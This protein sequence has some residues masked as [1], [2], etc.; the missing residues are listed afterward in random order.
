M[1]RELQ[2]AALPAVIGLMGVA[3]YTLLQITAPQPAP[4]LEAPRPISV[5]VEPAIR[6]LTRPT[7]V[8]FGEVRPAVRTE[9]VAQVGGKVVA[10]S[11]AFIEGGK[12][13]PDD[14]LLSIEDTDYRAAMEEVVARV[15][16]AKLEL[17]QALADADVARK[18]LAAQ[19]NPSPLALR[20][21]QVARAESALR[22]AQ[23][24]LSLAKT[25][26]ERTQ[27]SLPYTGRVENKFVD[28]GQYVNPGKV[29]G[30]VFGTD[31]VQVR[32]PLTTNQLVALAVPI[33]YQGTADGGLSTTL[34]ATLGGAVHRWQGTLTGLDAAIDPATRTVYGTVIIEDP[35]SETSSVVDMPLAVGLY[36][37]AEVEG[38]LMVDAV[39]I[40]SAGLRAGDKIFVLTGE[41]LLDIRQADVVHRSRSN[42]LLSAGVE[43]GEQVIVSAIR[44]P[45]RGMRLQTIDGAVIADSVTTEPANSDNEA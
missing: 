12:F 11:P 45:V 34:T 13:T 9:L 25:N 2:R 6:T 17:E 26:L 19:S 36:V 28:L 31:V 40:P 4:K 24:S 41:G 3:A 30:T 32:L 7:V 15:A 35:Y 8:A 37:D 33:G 21:P 10:T 42:A 18:Q 14:V 1:V 38:R 29:L 23:T 27:I 16:A 5:K 39:Q 43:P 20:E 44:N 22:A